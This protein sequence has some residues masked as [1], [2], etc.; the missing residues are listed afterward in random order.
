M[1]KRGSRNGLRP[2]I[3]QRPLPE[4]SENSR[5]AASRL[6]VVAL[7]IVVG[8]AVL[9][10]PSLIG[11][12]VL[13]PLDVLAEPY[14]YLPRTPD[15]PK[16]VLH[17]AMQTDLV[18]YYEP[19]RQFAISELRAG[20]L[21]FWSPSEFGGVGCFRW[22][23][24]PP[25]LLGYLIASPVALAWIQMLIA[26]VAGGGAY[27][28]FR[29]VMRLQFWPAAIVAW[30]YPLTGAYVL[31]QGFWLPSVM[32]WLPWMFAAV[33]AT[34]RRPGG[35]GGPLL[36]LLSGIVLLSGAPDIGGQVLLASGIYAVWCVFD[37]HGGW[38]AGNAGKSALVVALAW[39]LGILASA[40]LLL[41]LADYMRTGS[42]V[43]ARSQGSEER[44]PL[45]L[46]ALP[47]VVLPNMYGSA[48]DGSCRIGA[49]TLQESSAGAYA[50][51]L[52][53]LFLAPLAW[54]SRPH[55]SI[56]ILA[57]VLGVVG[58]AW[59]L[60]VPI[61]VQLLRMPGMNLMSHNRLVFATAFAILILA[62]AGL[63]VLWQ[64]NV[65]RR[66]WFLAPMSILAGL[67]AWC[68]YCAAI[69]PEPIASQLAEV[70]QQG[71]SL[72]GIGDAA[73]VPVIQD[74][75]RRSFVLAAALAGLGVAAW[76]WLWVRPRW[77]HW[78]LGV[79]AAV[80]VADLLWFGYGFAAQC[81][82]GLYY[83]RL[84]VLEQVAAAGPGRVIGMECLPAN[85]AATHRLC[86]VRG[87]DGVDPADWVELL[88]PA[89][90]PGSKV[91]PYA[92]TQWMD[93]MGWPLP[94]GGVKVSPILTM[95]N[96]RYVIYRGVPA[97]GYHPAFQGVDYFAWENPEALPRAFVPRHVEMIADPKER[98][99]RLSATDFDPR[100]VGFV[101][102][103]LDLPAACD[104]SV[105]ITEDTPRRVAI[106]AEMRT[107]GLIVL[108]DR[109]DRAWNAYLDGKPVAALRTNHA[110]RGV[111]VPAGRQTV[112][113]RFEPPS[114]TRGA[115]ISAL[116]LLGWLAWVGIVARRRTGL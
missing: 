31:W 84:P 46:E 13:L 101:E 9:Y 10:G 63:D 80:L 26:L 64:G 14:V 23:L 97:A 105:S 74:S 52:A 19:A 34:V 82:P 27:L 68:L 32:C 78:V 38:F 8:Q 69:L 28:F 35:W 79:L 99:T 110:V 107:P 62:A 53:T 6:L 114:L 65:V 104:G 102:Q 103:P 48:C 36:A 88:K 54:V 4:K 83:P 87:Y 81:D 57:A 89:A 111:V 25:W 21:P 100:R 29:R 5:S 24:S 51:L 58:L 106:A 66:W 50:G 94:Q 16:N 90:D 41:P 85:L 55:R 72:H 96:V 116:A 22:N 67:S 3:E 112:E 109:W 93:P 15:M 98:L 40:W 20:R 12:R 71:K 2:A 95:L 115:V 39:T 45:G 60:N 59:S 56:C 42:R 37:E 91:L 18:F 76:S 44:P 11:V 61:L 33:N 1:K 108:A 77:P 17:D 47:Q 73:S 43:L 30:C 86:D 75:Y 113:F 92:S 70:I 49:D 7:G